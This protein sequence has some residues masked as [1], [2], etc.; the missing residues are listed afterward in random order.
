MRLGPQEHLEVWTGLVE[1]TEVMLGL[2]FRNRQVVRI[3][4]SARPCFLMFLVVCC[5]SCISPQ[6]SPFRSAFL[7]E[8]KDCQTENG[9]EI[10]GDRKS[11][12]NLL[13][14]IIP[15]VMTPVSMLAWK[16]QRKKKQ[17]QVNTCRL[18]K[19]VASTKIIFCAKDVENSVSS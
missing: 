16:R 15:S 3:C 1:E 5:N 11:C 18:E 6:P 9:C 2:V 8:L 19:Q 7:P 17:A 4:T 10:Q 13:F 12:R 14:S